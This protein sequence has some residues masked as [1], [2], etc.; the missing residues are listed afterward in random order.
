LKIVVVLY[1]DENMSDSGLA[2]GDDFLPDVLARRCA[3]IP[4][5]SCFFSVHPAYNG[6]L[7][8]KEGVFVRSDRDDISFWKRFFAE[9]G[10]DHAVKVWADSPFLDIEL[11]NEMIALHKDY[12]AEFT[13]SENL[14]AGYSCEIMSKELLQSVPESKEALMPLGDAVRKNINQFD[15]ELFYKDPDIR[16]MRLSFR[17]GEARERRIME[18]IAKVAGGRPAYGKV[19]EIIRTNP[20]TLFVGPAYLEVEL[21]G[22]C[23]LDCIFCY[24]TSLP[25]EHGDM[26]SALY[27]KMLAGMREFELPYSLC[28]GG[29]GE[30]LMHKGVYDI[31]DETL[32]EDLVR[33]LV[34]ETNALYADENFRSYVSEKGDGRIRVIANV[35]GF[36]ADTYGRLHGSDRF[37]TVH[38]NLL[39]LREALPGKDS[40][41]V[42]VMKINETEAFLDEYYDFWEK[43]GIPIILQ[44]QDTV[45]GRI[46]DRRYSDLSPLDRTP[47]WHLQR[48]LYILSDGR[49]AFCKQDVEGTCS[50]GDLNTQGIKEIWNNS[51]PCFLADY[52]GQYPGKP[53]CASCDEWYTFNF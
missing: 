3:A 19:R 8:G 25:A 10:C 17:C 46:E 11:L 12:L 47:C 27:K 21:T 29:S 23:D 24:R 41:Y 35:N 51:L 31:L 34:I 1:V 49:A 32:R 5:I 9:S 22:R 15:V 26:D 4:G 43:T 52:R 48:D 18:N 30:P 7:T 28:L 37:S 39:G 40:L 38:R 53:D 2:F 42:Q 14:P 44:K 13:Y 50:R 36:N 33:N 45:L 16:D 6:T 20:E